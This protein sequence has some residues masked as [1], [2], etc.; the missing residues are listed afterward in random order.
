MVDMSMVDIKL[1]PVETEILLSLVE[2]ARHGYGIKLA[3][4]ERTNGR[5]RLGSGTLYVA[6]QRLEKA[7]LLKGLTALKAQKSQKSQK[8]KTRKPGPGTEKLRRRHFKLSADGRRALKHELSHLD[9]LLR[10]AK[11]L[12]SL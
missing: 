1:T 5:V 8:S 4:E 3:V 9:G 7:G 10:H 6:L 2:E 12:K 11:S